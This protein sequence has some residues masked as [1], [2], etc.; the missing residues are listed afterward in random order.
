M[1]QATSLGT[2]KEAACGRLDDGRRG[3]QTHDVHAHREAARQRMQRC[4]AAVQPQEAHARRDA[5]PPCL[6]H[7]TGRLGFDVAAARREAAH[8]RRDGRRRPRVQQV[9]L[10]C[11]QRAPH[12]LEAPH[13]LPDRAEARAHG[14]AAPGRLDG[15]GTPVHLS[16][17][18]VAQDVERLGEVAPQEDA[19][20]A[21]LRRAADV[22]GAEDRRVLLDDAAEELGAELAHGSARG[23]REAQRRRVAREQ[24]HVARVELGEGR[25]VREAAVAERDGVQGALAAE[26]R[27]E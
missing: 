25:P 2:R 24:E 18:G 11:V 9:R 22:D 17:S 6:H 20:G 8:G 1:A 12:G 21:E 5:P 3:E 16:D 19:R 23:R 27:V 4:H 15:D 14:V 26:L 13:A 10:A 7:D